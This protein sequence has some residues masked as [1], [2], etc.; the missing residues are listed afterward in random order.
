M[1]DRRRCATRPD[2][3][4]PAWSTPTAWPGRS[5]PL[6]LARTMSN[7][8]FSQTIAELTPIPAVHPHRR[9]AAA[10]RSGCT[11]RR[12]SSG[13]LSFLLA[14]GLDRRV[15]L[16]DR[17]A[18]PPRSA[19]PKAKASRE[20][21]R[22]RRRPGRAAP[23]ARWPAWRLSPFRLLLFVG[24]QRPELAGDAEQPPVRGRGRDGHGLELRR[25]G[26]RDPRRRL[27]WAK[28]RR[29]PT[30]RRGLRPRLATLACI[31][32][33]ARV[34][35]SPA[36]SST[37]GRRGPDDRPGRGAALVPARG[38]R[39]RRR[40]G[41]P[42]RF[43]GFHDRPRRALRVSPR[44]GRKVFADARLEVI[45]AELYERYLDLSSGSRRTTRLAGRASSTRSGRRWS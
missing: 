29:A 32:A 34:R 31:V 14:D 5:Y 38:G 2:R 40:E 16:R 25:V 37:H 11:S 21:S 35:W 28:C 20:G 23:R 15:R 39:V 19:G 36:A 1:A 42:D 3:A 18:G 9:A 30:R 27:R 6:E 41:M 12:W 26:R 24:L 33:T 43:L 7:P 8:V 17:G 10:S 44:A 13:R 22:R 4:W 45:G